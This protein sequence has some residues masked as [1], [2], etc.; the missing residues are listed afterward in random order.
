MKYITEIGHTEL[1]RHTHT[2]THNLMKTGTDIQTI[3]GFTYKIGTCNVGITGGRDL[4]IT[5]TAW[6][7]VP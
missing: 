7:Q 5:L 2:Y 3:L 4:R 1:H 6:I